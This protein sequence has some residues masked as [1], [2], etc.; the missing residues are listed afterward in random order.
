MYQTFEFLAVYHPPPLENNKHTI[1]S[2][3]DDFVEL[4]MELGT[5]CT[6]LTR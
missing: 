2:F 1:Q 5:A 6:N 3:I 4:R